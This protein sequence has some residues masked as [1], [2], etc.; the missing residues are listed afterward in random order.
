M[1]NKIVTIP[2]RVD[3]SIFDIKKENYKLHSSLK[4]M[5]VGALSERKNQVQLVHDLKSTG[6]NIELTLA[7]DGPL[8]SSLELMANEAS[9]NVRVRLTGQVNH[10]QLCEVL[11]GQDCYI[12]YSHSE[13]TPRAILE[14]MALN[15]PVITVDYPYMRG[16]IEDGRNALIMSRPEPDQLARA[17]STL[18]ES[19]ELRKNLA[20][21]GR[22][23]I[24]SRF[25]SKKVFAIYRD[26]ILNMSPLGEKLS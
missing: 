7:G 11:S 8:R 17:L 20:E 24:E 19:E 9:S 21:N 26:S 22:K 18:V 15:I 14:A 25:D 3:T 10:Q 23:L 16:I 13:G 6:L 1:E 12:H 5:M 2:V 4:I